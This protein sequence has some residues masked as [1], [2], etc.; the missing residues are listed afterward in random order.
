MLPYF[1]FVWVE[2]N[3]HKRGATYVAIA[4]DFEY[5]VPDAEQGLHP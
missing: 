5:I 2:S 4:K 1:S 3:R